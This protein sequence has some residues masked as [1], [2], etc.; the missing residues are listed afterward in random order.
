M[1]LPIPSPQLV[2]AEPPKALD[3]SVF[4]KSHVDLPGIGAGLNAL[5]QGLDD[6]A[7]TLAEQKARD[8]VA[9]W[10]KGV[11][12]D[13]D[14]IPQGP[15]PPS[16][17]F[18]FGAAGKVYSQTAHALATAS[19]ASTVS[20]AL[21]DLR[22]K[23]PDAQTFL[24]SFTNYAKQM[25]ERFPGA[26][27]EDAAQRVLQIG[28]QHYAG[29]MREEAAQT[30][31]NTRQAITTQIADG[32][33]H[34]A[35]LALTG[36]PDTT[37]TAD[38][39]IEWRRQLV[40]NPAFGYTAE[41]AASDTKDQAFREKVYSTQGQI[42]RWRDTGE[43]TYDQIDGELIKLRDDPN[44]PLTRAENE[45]LYLAG[46]ARLD[47]TTQA[48][49]AQ[50]AGA[51]T[52]A[53]A[54]LKSF[55]DPTAPKPS[56][57]DIEA[58][59]GTAIKAGAPDVF[60]RLK[61]MQEG[62]DLLTNMRGL[63]PDQKTAAIVG[64]GLG[65]INIV[66]GG[67]LDQ[68]APG[69]PSPKGMFDYLTSIGASKNEALMLTGAAASESG[70]NPTAWHD[71][72]T[73]YGLFGHRLGRL[74]AMRQDAGSFAPNWQQQAA[75]ALKEL[76]SRP[77]GAAVNAA[78]DVTELTRAQMAFEQPQGYTAAS[79]EGG[80]N[81]SGRLG[82]LN[83]FASLSGLP[84]GA[85]P[86]AAGGIPYTPQQIADNPLLASTYIAAT[87][88]DGAQIVSTAKNI[89]AGIVNAYEGGSKP[90]VIELAAFRQAVAQYPTE[91]SE[92]NTKIEQK[93]AA[94]DIAKVTAPSESDGRAQI[95][96]AD[97]YALQN[98][99]IIAAAG[100]KILRDQ[101]EGERRRYTD[102]PLSWLNTNGYS[103][104]GGP[105]PLDFATPDAARM[106]FA[107]RGAIV[108]HAP[109]AALAENPI[110]LIRGGEVD[111][112]KNLLANGSI[113]QKV[114]FVSALLTSGAPERS[115]RATLASFAKDSE[116]RPLAIAGAIAAESP[117][118]ARDVLMGEA[119]MKGQGGEKLVPDSKEATPAFLKTL[120]MNEFPGGTE[121]RETFIRG[122]LAVYAKLSADA[123][124][125]S[126]K[127]NQERF[128]KAVNAVT[129]GV[130]DF[131]GGKIIAP[132][133]GAD[134]GKFDAARRSLTQADLR[135]AVTADGAPFPVSALQSRE[136]GTS[137]N[138]RLQSLSAGRYL[139]YSGDD[140]NRR[141]V[142]R[143]TYDPLDT[144]GPFVLDLGS[145][146]DIVD[147]MP[148]APPQRLSPPGLAPIA[149]PNFR[150]TDGKGPLPVST[151]IGS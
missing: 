60:Y 115:I 96:Q 40:Q 139:I 52:T 120:P 88:R 122:A 147:K 20:P 51:R 98:P 106:E 39:V 107:H 12:L 141:Y 33:A 85:V 27:G 150:P 58:L 111:A 62:Y 135:E 64:N 26:L 93:A 144:G 121:T 16:T 104:I 57:A 77:E 140:A 78:K 48:Q 101:I 47:A 63:T 56:K 31:Q 71:N 74:D 45:K 2:T 118:A 126:G 24:Q 136:L 125:A 32:E 83:R 81:Y 8:D 28:N 138:W 110:P 43:R 145:K 38:K 128:D 18:M 134:Y 92:L 108:A 65:R 127:L 114:G 9:A 116:T 97:A 15:P 87:Q 86:A 84:Q 117:V 61:S 55:A 34:L 53:D 89:G 67:A 46:K 66:Y 102:D 91:L 80:H 41:K 59:M 100:A 94:R 109:P 17:E 143:Q 148:I 4:T 14:G 25:T 90:N 146:R 76:R 50:A 112:A 5:G 73:G 49:Q 3:T 54:F 103:K 149:D 82:T 7:T 142:Q 137:G 37:G 72:N 29:M 79:P 42:Q 119:L 113:D 68:S 105:G 124:D 123:G 19:L 75:F 36:Q 133:Y 30:L 22:A 129:G 70:L 1:E 132:W 99:G 11:A 69:M 10:S 44:S 13:K 35:Q 151:E 21:T 131:R 130:I 23:A 95:A 6:M